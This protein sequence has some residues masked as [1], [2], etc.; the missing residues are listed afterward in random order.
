[1]L[2]SVLVLALALLFA[3]SAAAAPVNLNPGDTIEFTFHYLQNFLSG[4]NGLEFDTG[5][6]TVN[7]DATLSFALYDGASELGS[8]GISLPG[9]Y[10]NFS[11]LTFSAFAAQ[12]SGLPYYL[13]YIDFTHV[14]D[15]TTLRLDITG[16]SGQFVV[17][18]LDN[19]S[20]GIS[21]LRVDSGGGGSG[22]SAACIDV[23]DREF[24]PDGVPEPATASSLA[25]AAAAGLF[26]MRCRRRRSH[27]AS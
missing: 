26:A 25:L 19:P 14:L 16:V 2:R 12:G 15:G 10:Q 11:A 17:N 24:I 6:G 20:W 1:M 7:P 3:A 27:T 13:D 5:S 18:N 9:Y 4:C 22:C 8:F 23:T 21:I